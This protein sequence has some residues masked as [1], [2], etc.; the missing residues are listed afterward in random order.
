[1]TL[2]IKFGHHSEF[3]AL[4]EKIR[5]ETISLWETASKQRITLSFMIRFPLPR[6]LLFLTFTT[7]TKKQP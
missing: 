2:K 3:G 7:R 6:L 5:Y 4:R 1:M